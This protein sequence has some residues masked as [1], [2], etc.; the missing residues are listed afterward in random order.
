MSSSP[1]TPMCQ[2]DRFLKAQAPV[3]DE[4]LSELR[5]GLKTS[6]WM[7]FIFPQLLGLARSETARKYGIADIHEAQAYLAHPILGARLR[8]CCGLL[9]MHADARPEQILGT[10][11]ALKL[12][13]SCTLFMK[14]SGNEDLFQSVLTAFYAGEPDASTL[15]LLEN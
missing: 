8:E 9:L 13:S 4:V 1:D 10:V 5:N 15:K 6:H 2:L 12:R 14:A 3:Y 11:D 7:W